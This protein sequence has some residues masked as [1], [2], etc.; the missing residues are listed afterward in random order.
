MCH[1]AG[2]LTLQVT[3]SIWPMLYYST[4]FLSRVNISYENAELISTT[5]LVIRY[6]FVD[7]YGH[8]I[9]QHT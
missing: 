4:E 1:I 2:V 5:M 6:F 7:E 3:T 8:K 9:Q